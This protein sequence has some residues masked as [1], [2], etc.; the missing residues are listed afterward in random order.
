MTRSLAKRLEDRIVLLDGG[1]GSALIARGLASGK[2]PEGWNLEHPDRVQ[3]VHAGYYAAGSDVVQTNTFGGSP[4]ILAKHGLEEKMEEINRAAA[5]IACAAAQRARAAAGEEKLVAGDIGPSGLLLPPVGNADPAELEKGF[6][7]QAAALAEGG[8]DYISIET[9]MDLNEALC[10]LR[11]AR[12]ATGLPVTACITF[13]RKKRG[14]FTMMGN[15]PEQCVK[16]LAEGGAIAVGANCSIGS[17]AMIELCPRLVEA[18]GVPVIVKPNAGLPDMEGGRPVYR[19]S[20]ED[21]AA[22][23]A[24]LVALGARAVGGCCGTDVRFIAAVRAELDRLSGGDD[25]GGGEAA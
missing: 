3:E 11:G 2:S 14:F 16:T 6:G 12:A 7:R 21:F 25:P 8:A 10:A 17:D 19:Q 5:R 18:A 20:P 4:F 13:D 23:A 24:R 9:M 1:M 15:T 22:D